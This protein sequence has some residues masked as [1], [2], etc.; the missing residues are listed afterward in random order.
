MCRFVAYLSPQE[1]LI[2]NIIEKPDNSLISQSKHSGAGAG[3]V[4]ADGLGIAWYNTDDRIPGIYKSIQPAW[5]NSNLK[6]LA[7]KI[8]SECFLGHVRASTIGG[9]NQSNCHPFAFHEF[10]F[11]HNGTIRKFKSIKRVLINTLSSELFLDIKGSTDS[12]H[13]FYLIMHYHKVDKL[14]LEESLLNAFKWV[15]EKQQDLDDTHYSK[16]NTALTD[17]HSLIAT[18]FSSKGNSCL[19]LFYSLVNDSIIISSE[20]LDTTSNDWKEVPEN[21]YLYVDKN[22]LSPVIKPI[23]L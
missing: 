16:I 15:V 9:I 5:N 18:R 1:E 7:R 20:Q 14:P 6:H 3:G 21:H 11:V 8:K 10:S 23:T 22:N 12:E 19:S 4:N 2:S 13:L 17:G